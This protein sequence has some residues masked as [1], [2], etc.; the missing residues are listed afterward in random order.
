[1][2]LSLPISA[3]AAE[4]DYAFGFCSC[5]PNSTNSA[6]KRCSQTNPKP[7]TVPNSRL[8]A[9]ATSRWMLLWRARLTFTHKNLE[10]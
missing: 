5:A 6:D 10:A 8:K 3:N 1:M 2:R 4:R 9:R 7:F